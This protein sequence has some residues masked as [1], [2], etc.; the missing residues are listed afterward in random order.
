MTNILLVTSNG[1]GMGHLTRQAAVALSMHPSNQA[2]IFSLSPGLPLVSELG[3]RCEYCPSYD[4]PWIASGQWNSYLYDRL[5]AVAE[6]TGSEAILFDGVFPYGGIAN[7]AWRLREVAFVWL[8][9]GMWKDTNLRALK[10]RHIF[11]LVIEPGDLASEDDTGP[12]SRIRDSVHVGPISI[13]EPLGMLPRAEARS[14]LGL[15]TEGP[16]ALVTLGSGMLGDVAGPG[17]MVVKTLLDKTGDWHVAVTKSP[18]AVNEIP[19]GQA[20]RL[21][22]LSG[23]YPLATYLSAFDM[24][25]SSAGYNA[26][27]ELTPAGVPSL[28]VANTSTQT[29]DQVTR[30]L[31]LERQGLALATVDNDLE[32]V[33]MK[34]HE[35][36]RDNRRDELGRKS[37]ETR[38]L[39]TGASETGRRMSGAAQTHHFRRMS[40]SDLA[41]VGV[42]RGKVLVQNTLGDERTESL[43]RMLGRPPWPVYEKAQVTLSDATGG[44]GDADHLELALVRS[45]SAEE[46][47]L[48]QPIEHLLAGS[49]DDY[50]Q[51]RREIID[52]Y[53]DVEP[54]E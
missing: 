54:D 9:R 1:T 46:L 48:N 19:V 43:K 10:K 22:Q 31:S 16:V 49:S 40:V 50:E 29:D 3:I 33:E 8:R 38:S 5:T 4:R 13:L 11:D 35:M 53:Y 21:T 34:L 6:E 27:H 2:T 51:K 41:R 44:G 36:V 12:T 17:G 32:S 18:V 15:P 25:V 52:L 24:A 14:R 47:R 39:M 45:L 30:A 28:L 42:E 20:K 23:V 37:R 26:V 7:A